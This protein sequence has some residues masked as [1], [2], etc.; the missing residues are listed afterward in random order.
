MHTNAYNVHSNVDV[1]PKFTASQILWRIRTIQNYHIIFLRIIDI[2]NL[3]ILSVLLPSILNSCQEKI[4]YGIFKYI[5]LT[6]HLYMFMV[7]RNISKNVSD[8]TIFFWRS[9]ILQIYIK[10]RFQVREFGMTISRL[11][12]EIGLTAQLWL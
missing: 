2:N 11:L 5:S 7:L 10:S 9:S 1:L 8:V 6:Q 4:R 12:A 3:K